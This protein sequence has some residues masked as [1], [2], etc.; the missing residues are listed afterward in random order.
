MANKKDYPKVKY[1][2]VTGN[3]P[4]MFYSW[5]KVQEYIT[6]IKEDPIFQ[7][8]ERFQPQ[9]VIKITEELIEI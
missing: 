2:L 5:D 8:E 6:K 1:R 3:G 9:Y 7:K 4:S